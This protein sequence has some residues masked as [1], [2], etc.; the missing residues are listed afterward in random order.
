MQVTVVRA[1]SSCTSDVTS[2]RPGTTTS[3]SIDA[4]I[5]RPLARVRWTS[6]ERWSS[7]SEATATSGRSSAAATRGSDDWDGSSS[8]ATS[9]DCTITRVRSTAS[10]S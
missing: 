2:T 8:L 6:T 7:V 1:Q 5:V 9:S 10:T 3:W 4:A